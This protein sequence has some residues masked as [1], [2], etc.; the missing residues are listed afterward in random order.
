MPNKYKIKQALTVYKQ[1]KRLFGPVIFL[2]K[3]FT[4]YS[5]STAF[6]HNS[7]NA[8][9]ECW[10]D[11]FFTKFVSFNILTTCTNNSSKAS[12]LSSFKERRNTSLTFFPP[13]SIA[14][15]RQQT[16]TTFFFAQRLIA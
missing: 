8:S 13:Q 16:E 3:L 2:F 12:Y 4:Y 14:F 7:I 11:S 5:T 1:C 6:C 10:L 9:K 15:S